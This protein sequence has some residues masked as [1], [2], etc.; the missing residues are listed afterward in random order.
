MMKKLLVTLMAFGCMTMFAAAQDASAGKN[1]P[2]GQNT[3]NKGDKVVN[4]G[5]GFGSTIYNG[6]HFTSKTPPISGTFELG[7]KDNLFD[8]KS[9][10]GV[11]GYLGYRGA[12]WEESGWGWKYTSIVIGIRG[13]VHYQLIDQLDTYTGIMLGYNIS[14]ASAF[15]TSNPGTSASSG[16]LTA[17]WYVGGRYYFTDKIAGMVELGYGVAILNLG[18]AIKL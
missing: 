18:V 7:I 1:V 15:G 11:G 16:G 9:S 17:S 4:L 3:F 2:S 8:E 10:L 6:S 12:K 5:I 14:S 13:A